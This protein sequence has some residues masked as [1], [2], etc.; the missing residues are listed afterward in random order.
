MSWF[1][2]ETQLPSLFPKQEEPIST[3][4]PSQKPG[5]PETPPQ[6]V[7]TWWERIDSEIVKQDKRTEKRLEEEQK[8]P[9]QNELGPDIRPA[10]ELIERWKKLTDPKEKENALYEIVKLANSWRMPSSEYTRI[11][12][13]AHQLKDY[14]KKKLAVCLN[15]T[16][17]TESEKK[18]VLYA[19]DTRYQPEASYAEVQAP[20]Q[21]R[22]ALG[23]W[24]F[25]W[26]L[27]QGQ[28][29]RIASLIQE[30]ERND[31]STDVDPSLQAA[32]AET[33]LAQILGF[34]DQVEIP[35]PRIYQ[36]TPDTDYYSKQKQNIFFDCCTE[37]RLSDYQMR[38]LSENLEFF[39][40]RMA[41]KQQQR[42]HPVEQ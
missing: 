25:E 24:K 8:N 23:Q 15:N 1:R 7:E 41:K 22:E 10:V 38:V 34:I 6:V 9:A 28:R 35:E 12:D 17:L 31:W 5:E 39:I 11:Y 13:T 2:R 32:L 20:S 21:N 42:E 33:L 36:G 26:G 14:R 30:W 4:T 37:A 16:K 18:E 40:K 27:N 19:F 3:D 29:K